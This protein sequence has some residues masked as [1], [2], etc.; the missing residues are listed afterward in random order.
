MSRCLMGA[1]ALSMAVPLSAASL[2]QEIERLL[3]AAPVS[4]S[5][6]WGI[7]IVDLASG[8]TLYSRNNNRLFV[9]ASN[10][11]LFTAALALD[12]LGPDF[13]FQT[14]LLSEAAPDADGRVRGAVRLV[15]GGD[16]NLSARAVPYRI[17]P[18]TGNPLAPLEDLADQAVARGVKIIERGIVGDDSWYVWEPFPDGW[19]LDDTQYEYG[20][21]V[22]ALTIND[23][24]FTLT[25]RPGVRAGDLAELTL[26]PPIEYYEIDNRV[27]TVPAGAERKVRLD[28]EPGSRQLRLWGTLP[29]RAPGEVLMLAMSDP[30]AYAAKAL[31]RALQDRGVTVEGGISVEHRFPNE[32]PLA[33]GPAAYELAR[34]D[35][36]PLIEDL[37]ITAKVSQNLHAELALRAVGRARRQAGSRQAGLEELKAFL[38]EIGIAP[39][40]VSLS[41]GSGLDR[42]DLVT[43]AAVIRL[44]RHMYASPA[45]ESWLSLLPVGGQDGTLS[46]RFPDSPAAGHIH[47]KT[48]TLNH[49]STLS[50]YAERR[51][52]SWLAFSVLVNNYSAQAAEVRSVMDRICTV[53]VE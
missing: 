2:A 32:E 1:L 21:P 20:A 50:G 39:E 34:R 35:S 10:A 9:P 36:A 42:T 24:T 15:G 53:I 12:R 4:R 25:V 47:A 29:V 30:A 41:D 26:A 27:R 3:D 23:N 45:R 48:G 37:R 44:L 51:D 18:V 11:K 38:G 8:K 22:S 7:E 14:R 46:A 28:R 19:A 33:A 52:G 49:V 13:R 40:A 5:A 43:P 16:P 31:L 17:G 6:F